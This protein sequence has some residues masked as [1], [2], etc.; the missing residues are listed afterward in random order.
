MNRAASVSLLLTWLWNLGL[1]RPAQCLENYGA[2]YHWD[3]WSPR[4]RPRTLVSRA[5]PDIGI[6]LGSWDHLKSWVDWHHLA[7]RQTQRVNYP[8]KF[9]IW[10]YFYKNWH[11]NQ[12]QGQPVCFRM[13]SGDKYFCLSFTGT[14]SLLESKALHW[15]LSPLHKW[16]VFLLLLCW[17]ES[18]R[19]VQVI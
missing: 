8:W 11:W 4:F 3:W 7:V 16:R 1:L 9:E 5:W 15:F 17:L 14:G 12:H 10:S 2:W 18:R 19:V 6:S 13:E